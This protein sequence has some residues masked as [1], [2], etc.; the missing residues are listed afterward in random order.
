MST[1]NGPGQPATPQTPVTP[2]GPAVP[3]TRP[4]ASPIA[5]AAAVAQQAYLDSEQHHAEVIGRARQALAPVLPGVQLEALETRVEPGD[6]VIVTDQVVT[7]VV[8]SD[9]AV[10]TARQEAGVYVQQRLVRNPRE[11]AQ[12][13]PAEVMH[14]RISRG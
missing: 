3:G 1:P 4:P 2:G 9:G 14:G 7:L 6:L 13:L 10:Y 11:L 8:R 5:D 12:A